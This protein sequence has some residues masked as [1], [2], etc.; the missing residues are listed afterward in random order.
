MITFVRRLPQPL[1]TLYVLWFV[2]VLAAVVSIALGAPNTLWLGAAGAVVLLTG[3]TLVTNLNRAADGLAA[4]MKDYRP[5]GVDY[6]R[7]WMA[8]PAYARLFGALAV[9][10]GVGFLVAAVVGR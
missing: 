8:T 9:V 2:A 6:S 5:M 7:S 3:L 1:K 10:V 4:A